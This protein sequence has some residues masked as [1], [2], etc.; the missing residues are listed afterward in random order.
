MV[1]VKAGISCIWPKVKKMV[2]VITLLS[3]E[4]NKRN[5]YYF[6]ERKNDCILYIVIFSTLFSI[7]IIKNFG[8]ACKKRQIYKHVIYFL[9]WL[10]QNAVQPAKTKSL[11]IKIWLCTPISC[12]A[13]T[14]SRLLQ[15]TLTYETRACTDWGS[16]DS[17]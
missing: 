16:V 17:V 4:S 7:L 15:G 6:I 10:I 8:A 9:I 2:T 1:W 3:F 14:N 12:F 11:I 5:D 13:C